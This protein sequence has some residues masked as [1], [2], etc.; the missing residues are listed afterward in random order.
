MDEGLYNMIPEENRNPLENIDLLLRSANGEVLKVLGQTQVKIEI[1]NQL[2]DYAVKVVAL[3]DNSA[4]LGLDFMADEECVLYLGQGLLQIGSKSVR[5]TLH[6]QSDSKCARIQIAEN[7]CIPP[8]QEMMVTGN[9]N[10][11]HRN[12]DEPFGAVEQTSPLAENKG[13]FEAANH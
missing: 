11:R 8:N 10:L 9:I 1:G 6:K 5:L 3:G 13:L 4:I 7:L 2:F 12:F